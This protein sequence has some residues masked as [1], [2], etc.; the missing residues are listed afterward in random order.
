MTSEV[1]QIDGNSSAAENEVS[2]IT[3]ARAEAT[4]NR[5][6]GKA[7]NA[8]RVT[9]YKE[10]QDVLEHAIRLLQKFLRFRVA[11]FVELSSSRFHRREYWRVPR[12]SSATR[13]RTSQ[14][15]RKDDTLGDRFGEPV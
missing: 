7:A 9:K 2:E 10:A 1:E 13:Q 6:A 14:R 11:V 3:N 4:C 8:R 15:M 5:E 12:K